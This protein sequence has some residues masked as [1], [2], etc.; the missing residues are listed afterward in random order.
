MDS[1]TSE[2]YIA[3]LEKKLSRLKHAI[4]PTSNDLVNNVSAMK[5][6]VLHDV[7]TNSTTSSLFNVESLETDPLVHFDVLDSLHSSQSED[8]RT[9]SAL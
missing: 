3:C 4:N 9:K 6:L 7:L 1:L 2:Q 5:S 8:D